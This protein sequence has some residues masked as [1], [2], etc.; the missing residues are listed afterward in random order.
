MAFVKSCR[1][2]TFLVGTVTLTGQTPKIVGDFA[3][4]EGDIIVGSAANFRTV[5]SGTTRSAISIRQ[6]AG[7][8]WPRVGNASEV[9]YTNPNNFAQAEETVRV[10]N[11]TFPGVI[12][13]VK[14]TNQLDYIEFQMINGGGGCAAQSNLGRVGGMQPIPGTYQDGA[15]SICVAVL[16]H[17][18]GHALGLQHEQSRADRDGY[19]R[20]NW[21][22]ISNRSQYD[23]P[24]N[25]VDFGFYDTA[26]IMHYEV[27]TFAVDRNDVT[28]ETIPTGM[29]VGVSPTYSAGDID[30]VRRLYSA[31]PVQVSVATNPPGLQVS[32]DD[33][34]VTGGSAQATFTWT[35]NSSHVLDVPVNLQ[36]QRLNGNDYAFGRWNDLPYN[37]D[38]PQTPRHT[39]TA[40]PGDGSDLVLPITSPKATIYLANFRQLVAAGNLIELAVDPADS[41]QTRI[42]TAAAIL[43]GSSYYY[44]DQPVVIRSIPAAGFNF[45]GWDLQGAA[46]SAGTNPKTIR[47]GRTQ[48]MTARFTKNTVTAITTNPAGL[49]INVDG[50]EFTGAKGFALPFDAAWTDGSN[51]T[52]NVVSPQASNGDDSGARSV[53]TSWSDGGAQS[54]DIKAAANT[55]LTAN[56]ATQFTLGATVNAKACAANIR[57]EPAAVDNYYN[58]GTAVTVTAEPAAGWN[59]VRWEGQAAGTDRKTVVTIDASKSIRAVLNTTQDPFTVTNISP[60]QAPLNGPAFT[61]TINGTGFSNTTSYCF[62]DETGGQS[63]S[64]NQPTFLGPNQL[65]ILVTAELLNKAQSLQL[66]LSNAVGECAINATSILPVRAN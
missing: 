34:I 51:H 63:R 17:E 32:A 47:A 55:T 16:L 12:Q 3:V 43:Q 35:P 25:S 59:F 45:Y 36:F 5:K 40:A 18:V 61:L 23:K 44:A 24:G 4:I 20:I 13:F 2:L 41:G 26:S 46:S 66:Q 50:V 28:M 19:V 21:A 42:E 60:I 56:F 39:I 65:T 48:R 62:F 22:N 9:P 30:V 54:H 53:F 6:T 38:Q 27:T 14:R 31:A 11:Q 64:C 37:V 58:S 33:L 8:L 29:P 49:K 10:F 52:I 7:S 15:E 57:L 1:Y